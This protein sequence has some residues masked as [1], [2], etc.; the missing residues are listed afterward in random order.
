MSKI[1]KGMFVLV[2]VITVLG[3]ASAL[4]AVA[5]NYQ[6]PT[7]TCLSANIPSDAALT[8]D[9]ICRHL[10]YA[11]GCAS[12]VVNSDYTLY[13]SSD[14]SG[15]GTPVTANTT[16]TCFSVYNNGTARRSFV[17]TDGGISCRGIEW[18]HRHAPEGIQTDVEYSVMNI[19][20]YILGFV[21]IICVIVVIYGLATGADTVKYGFLGLVVCGL[22][23][24]MVVVISTVV[25]R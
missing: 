11:G 12:V 6:L 3:V 24:A 20:N 15:T 14:C 4:S 1:T 21:S 18:Q 5:A 2:F 17:I 13:N 9:K 22:A 7:D 23:Y 19:V 8:P 16:D 25:L 10:G